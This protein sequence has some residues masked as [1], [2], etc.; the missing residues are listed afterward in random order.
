MLLISKVHS[1]IL[2]RKDYNIDLVGL[3]AIQNYLTPKLRQEFY[4]N[5]N[6]TEIFS[7]TNLLN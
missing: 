3:N 7:E 1:K 5:S 2:R 6:Y 4:S